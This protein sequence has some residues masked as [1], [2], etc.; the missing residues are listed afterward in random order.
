MEVVS[1]MNRPQEDAYLV[2]AAGLTL[3][4]ALFPIL[5]SIQKIGPIPL[6]ELAD[7]VGRN[8]TT[9]SRQVSRLERLGFVTR[10]PLDI[11]RRVRKVAIT[12][13]GKAAAKRID[14]ARERLVRRILDSWTAEEIES[15][16]RLL[17]KLAAALSS[18]N[19]R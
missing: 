7:R 3:D 6:V 19:R 8:Y 10:E 14:A 4:R 12:A 2:R 15:L 17:R 18:G 5:V 11:D 1:V 9:V 16:L 13:A